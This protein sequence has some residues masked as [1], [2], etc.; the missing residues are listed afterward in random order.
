MI[1]ANMPVQMIAVVN[2]TGDMIPLRFRFEGE[3]HTIQT[4]NIEKTLSVQEC[5]YVGQL[6]MKYICKAVWNNRE[7]L[8]EMKYLVASHK[9]VL[10]QLLN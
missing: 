6:C 2:T 10:S 1:M 4:V 7:Y 5:N 3:D 8:F 9:W